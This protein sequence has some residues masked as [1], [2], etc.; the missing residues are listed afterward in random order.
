MDIVQLKKLLV[1]FMG[2]GFI[3][4]LLKNIKN[5]NFHF[6]YKRNQNIVFDSYKA[7]E[8]PY[9][10]TRIEAPGLYQYLFEKY[11]Q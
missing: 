10:Y 5:K 6:E 2:Q 8:L 3:L 9:L 7:V 1:I 11:Y 4:A